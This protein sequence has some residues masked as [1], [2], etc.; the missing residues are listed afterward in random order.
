MGQ[1]YGTKRFPC[2]TSAAA[3]SF[4]CDINKPED[5]NSNKPEIPRNYL[6]DNCRFIEISKMLLST[7]PEVN[8]D[9]IVRVGNFGKV[10]AF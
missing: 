5:E 2:I 6:R 4:S 9:A 10:G 1:C 7:K 8:V 3:E